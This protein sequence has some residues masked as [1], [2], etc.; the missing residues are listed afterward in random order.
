VCSAVST[1]LHR[2]EKARSTLPANPNAATIEES[3]AHFLATTSQAT[4]S[5]RT[6]LRA[7]GVPNTPDGSSSE[8]SIAGAFAQ[9]NATINSASHS[10]ASLPSD[11][12]AGLRTQL[13]VLASQVQTGVDAAQQ[14]LQE[15]SRAEP[16]S[17]ALTRALNASK[18]CKALLSSP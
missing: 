17:S 6:Q 10:L 13:T 1:W 18:A 4:Q 12:P 7:S 2:V 16:S 11:S 9:L 14:T 15:A 3:L 8:A 5:L